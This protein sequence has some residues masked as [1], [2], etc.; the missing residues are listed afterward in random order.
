MMRSKYSSLIGMVV[1]LILFLGLDRWQDRQGRLA[2]QNSEFQTYMIWIIVIGLVIG[3]LL[4]GLSWLTLFQS[5]RSSP[6][7]IIFIIV[8]V[9]VYIYPVLYLWAPAWIS[10]LPLPYIYSY[11]TPF[12]Y[13]G[14]FLAVLGFLHFSLPKSM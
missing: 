5:Q 7:S 9:I 3:V 13:T 2:Q 12:A 4:Y 11:S 10:W 14:I 8:G 1:A 6:I